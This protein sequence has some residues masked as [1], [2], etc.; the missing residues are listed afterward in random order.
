MHIDGLNISPKGIQT[1]TRCRKCRTPMMKEGDQYRCPK[2]GE[3]YNSIRAGPYE[4]SIAVPK[5]EA[6]KAI[7]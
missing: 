6:K 2:C 7:K 5:I 4:K 3:K 1:T